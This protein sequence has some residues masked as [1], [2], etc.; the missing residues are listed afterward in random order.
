MGLGPQSLTTL[1]WFNAEEIVMVA[2]LRKLCLKS[3]KVFILVG[4]TLL[5]C[6]LVLRPSNEEILQPS[7]EAP[8]CTTASTTQAPTLKNYSIDLELG[9]WDNT[10]RFKLHDN[11]FVGEKFI[12]LSKRFDV[13]LAT[14]SS[15]D[16]L[17][18]ITK[19][20]K[21]WN[22]PV[23]VAV[24]V[25]DIEL[26][27]ALVYISK[28]RQCFEEIRNQV[29]FHFLYPID[30]PPVPWTDDTQVYDDCQHP[31]NMLIQIFK[32]KR[33]YKNLLKDYTR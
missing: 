22:G 27:A 2:A 21:T 23:S 12:E 10:R 26:E 17:H 5:N 1:I 18:W 32:S 31:D 16:R 6:Y 8:I 24:F 15:L 30:K 3:T 7:G 11:V 14:Q 25:P 29:S 28:L 20:L 33:Y 19:S 13:T 4:I 9:R